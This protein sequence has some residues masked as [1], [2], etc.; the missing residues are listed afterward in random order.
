MLNRQATR[1]VLDRLTLSRVYSGGI[2]HHWLNQRAAV[3]PY[4][5]HQR[6]NPANARPAGAD[7]E[8]R[9]RPLETMPSAEGDDAGSHVSSN[10]ENDETD[11]QGHTHGVAA[12]LGVGSRGSGDALAGILLKRSTSRALNGNSRGIG[13]SELRPSRKQVFDC[14][15]VFGI[16]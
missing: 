4:R 2:A 6:P 12:V 13:L 11:K 5:P 1:C 15:S 16:G 14:L 9:N 8:G 3:W 7:I 10:A